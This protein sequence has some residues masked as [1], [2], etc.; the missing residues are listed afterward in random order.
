M[1]NL[2][3]IVLIIL[4]QLALGETYLKELPALVRTEDNKP[5]EEVVTLIDLISNDGF[6]GQHFK[7][8]NGKGT[9]AISFRDNPD[10]TF[11]AATAY[12]HLTR[13][14]EYFLTNLGSSYVASLPKMIIRLEHINKFSKLG[15][16][17]NDELEPQY[18]NALTIPAGTGLASRGVRPWD[19][20]IWFRPSKKIHISE[21]KVHGSE[22]A[23]YK[24]LM[25]SYRDQSRV[26]SLSR[27]LSQGISSMIDSESSIDP[28]STNSLIR[29]VGSSVLLE[30]AYHFYDPL[31]KVF[32]Q[33]W[34]WLDTAMVPEI[35][36]HEFA[37]AAL[38]DHLDLTHSTAVI[39]GMADFFAGQIADS[40]KLA[41][42]IR[43]HNTYNGKNARNKQVFKE[44]FETA[45]Y[46]NT[47]FVFGLLW[48]MKRIVGAENGDAFMYELRKKLTTS[49]TIK[50]QL[51][52]G[53]LQTCKRLCKDP[54]SDKLKIQKA[55]HFKGI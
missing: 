16:F 12:Y 15:H 5:V 10:L 25:K 30:A 40:P 9:Q 24:A 50:G 41:T 53:I 43:D 11:R 37:H 27:F 19:I 4:P 39:E 32:Q 3:L 46:A 21:I 18:N 26:Q 45:E 7:I 34:Y 48:E 8:V 49:A 38:S 28:F 35:I 6:D 52:E 14:R 54:F 1:R 44:I 2:I 42:H 20:E 51:I 22:A 13:A 55:L 36:Y 29:T 47:D 17:A 31:T 33:K 23:E